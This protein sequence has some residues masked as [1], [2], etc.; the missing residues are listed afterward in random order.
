MFSYLKGKFFVVASDACTLCILAALSAN[1]YAAE[2]APPP[3]KEG[4]RC[5]NIPHALAIYTQQVEQ[6]FWTDGNELKQ[7]ASEWNDPACVFKD[8]R[9]MLLAMDYG[10]TNAFNNANDW[11]KGLERVNELKRRFPKEAFAALTESYYWNTYAWNARGGGYSSS[12]SEVGQKLFQKRLEKA[13]RVLLETKSYSS[14]LPMWYDQMINVQSALGRPKVERDRVF[15]EGISRYPT[16]YPIYFTMLNYL[17]PKWGGTWGAVD[18]M[19]E[20]SVE[21]TKLHE[22][23]SIYSRLYWFVNENNDVNLFRDTDAS[24]P[25]MKRGFEDMMKRYPESKWNLNNFDKFACMAGDKQTFLKIRREIGNDVM[26]AAW[27]QKTSLDLCE[28]KFG[29]AQ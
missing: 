14:N 9:P 1:V 19:V 7:L 5:I 3:I 24:W 8:G 23:L 21:H 27:P 12:V 2:G 26:D 16:Y 25:K 4:R 13:E 18:Q 22:G 15:K 28:A 11:G 6:I 17:Q 29:L 20:R 10:Y